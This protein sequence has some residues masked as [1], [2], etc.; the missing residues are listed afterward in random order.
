[1]STPIEGLAALL[2]AS[3][4]LPTGTS[5]YSGPTDNLSAPAVV[6]RPDE[7]WM[8]PGN[9]FCHDLQRYVAIAL[10]VAASPEDGTTRLYRMAQAIIEAVDSAASGWSWVSVGSA[11]VDESTG[12]AFLAAPV[13]LQ[14]RNGDPA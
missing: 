9:N 6:I 5:I 14:F 11:L 13:R 10:V 12:A 3:S 4:D 7:P 2:V 1:M 8:E